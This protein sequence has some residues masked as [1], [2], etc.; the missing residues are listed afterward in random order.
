M[1]W[2]IIC[3]FYNNWFVGIDIIF[4]EVRF[5]NFDSFGCMAKR[6]RWLENVVF[7]SNMNIIMIKRIFVIVWDVYK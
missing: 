2:F 5:D 4:I 7:E 6:G 3:V 1:V